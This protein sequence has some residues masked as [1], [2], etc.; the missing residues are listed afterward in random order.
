[1]I[2]AILNCKFHN[3]LQTDEQKLNSVNSIRNSDEILEDQKLKEETTEPQNN[4]TSLT[5]VDSTPEGKQIQ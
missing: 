4:R 5:D 3:E 2:V 1:M